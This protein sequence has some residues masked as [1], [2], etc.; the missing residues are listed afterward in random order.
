MF[1]VRKK[2]QLLSSICKFQIIAVPAST[3]LRVKRRKTENPSEVL[4]LSAK[5]RK[6]NDC[7][8]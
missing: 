4:V 1:S 3:I 5:R 6:A 8:G 2:F 7:L